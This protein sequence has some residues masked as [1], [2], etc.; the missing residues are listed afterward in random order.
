MR[1]TSLPPIQAMKPLLISGDT[2]H[3]AGIENVYFLLL[4][5]IVMYKLSLTDNIL[6]CKV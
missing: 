6:N 1:K 2:V 3:Q 5:I 4:I